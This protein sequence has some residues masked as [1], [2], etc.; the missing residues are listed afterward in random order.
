MIFSNNLG[1]RS[2]WHKGTANARLFE[3]L[4]LT[5]GRADGCLS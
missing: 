4:A 5:T 3:I 2:S 1:W